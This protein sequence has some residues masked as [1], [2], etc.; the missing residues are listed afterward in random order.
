MKHLTFGRAAGNQGVNLEVSLVVR[1]I[2]EAQLLGLAARAT[3]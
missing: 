2:L 3:V 1:V